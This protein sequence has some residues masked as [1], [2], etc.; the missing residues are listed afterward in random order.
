MNLAEE[1]TAAV[2]AAW[3]DLLGAA[4]VNDDANFFTMGGDSLIAVSLC[5]RLEKRFKVRPKLRVLFDHPMFAEYV[6]ELVKLMRST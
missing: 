6:D 1:V 5:A 3:E 4:T 2:R